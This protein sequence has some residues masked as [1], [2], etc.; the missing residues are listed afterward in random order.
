VK[1][2][3]LVVLAL[4]VLGCSSA[5]AASG[6]FALGFESYD[7]TIQYCDYEVLTFSDPY[8]AGTHNLTTSCGFPY[9][10]AMVGLKTPLPLA[11]GLPVTGTTYALADNTFDAEYV[12][13]TGCQI[14]WVTKTKAST[15][16]QK[17]NGKFG[18]QFFYTCGGGGDYLG[19]YGFLTTQLGAASHG[20]GALPLR[21][22]QGGFE[23]TVTDP[24]CHGRPRQFT[25]WLFFCSVDVP[26]NL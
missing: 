22:H 10:G 25:T 14:D 16:L 26:L 20:L 3:R 13:F 11:T 23:E 4:I 1:L 2:T 19:N 5:F 18:W 8:I 12:A 17:L 7:Q 21:F 9:D 24:Y 15:K 6:S